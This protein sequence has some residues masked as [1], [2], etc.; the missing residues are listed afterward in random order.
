MELKDAIID[1][2]NRGI[3]RVHR[4]TMTSPEIFQLELERVFQKSWLYVG[5]DSEIPKPGDYLRR[6]VGG[7]P[8]MFVRGTDGEP[9]VF[10]NTCPHRGALVCRQERGNASLFQCFYHAWTFNNQGDLVGMPEEEG[11]AEGFDRAERSLAPPARVENY[12]GMVFL[13]YNPEVEDLVDYLGEARIFLDA[14]IDQGGEEGIRVL[15]GTY[16]LSVKANWKLM[17]E[18]TVDFYHVVPAHI[19]WIQYMKSLGREVRSLRSD[20]TLPGIALGNGH[21]GRFSIGNQGSGYLGDRAAQAPYFPGEQKQRLQKFRGRLVKRYGQKM[22]DWTPKNGGVG[23]FLVYPNLVLA[24]GMKA[25]R[26]FNPIAPDVFEFTTWSVVPKTQSDDVI[27]KV[28]R[29]D[30]FDAQGPGGFQ[31]PDDFEALESCQIGFTAQGLGWSD[32]SRG[33]HRPSEMSDEL[34]MRV[35]WRQW[36]AEM[37]SLPRGVRTDDWESL[38]EQERTIAAGALAGT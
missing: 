31:Q 17:V 27:R 23:N 15:P 7:Q 11:Y 25:I 6:K 34:P 2:R 14:V 26:V 22:A 37:L 35:F 8:I 16:R 5:H 29:E 12:R 19:T 10:L 24:H 9:R 4:S 18:N 32:I 30:F 20:Y 36:H 21:T 3:F 33:M 1:D 28:N 38:E 13:S